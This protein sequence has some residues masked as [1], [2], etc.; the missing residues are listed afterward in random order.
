[1]ATPEQVHGDRQRAQAGDVLGLS[2]GVGHDVGGVI[3]DVDADC[4]RGAAVLLHLGLF[5][6]ASHGT[7]ACL[8]TRHGVVGRAAHTVTAASVPTFSTRAPM[9]GEGV[10]CS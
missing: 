7:E 4:Y 1:M 3:R 8:R 10:T 5:E 2:L 6:I 9:S